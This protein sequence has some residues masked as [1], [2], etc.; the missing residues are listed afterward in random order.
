[1]NLLPQRM[2]IKRG[3][4]SQFNTCDTANHTTTKSIEHTGD[5]LLS[6]CIYEIKF[7]AP[8]MCVHKVP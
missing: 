8:D 1:M 7:E 5:E 4:Y 3:V 2:A 6:Y